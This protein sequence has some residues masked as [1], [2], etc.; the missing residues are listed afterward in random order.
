MGAPGQSAAAST[1]PWAAQSRAFATSRPGPGEA[2]PPPTAG[3]P[4]VKIR[5]MTDEG[6]D[7]GPPKTNVEVFIDDVLVHSQP[8]PSAQDVAG[9]DFKAGTC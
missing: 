4:R 9:T 7:A 5:Y 3:E 8:L 2:A 6:P 1:A